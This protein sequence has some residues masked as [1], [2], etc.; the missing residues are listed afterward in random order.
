MGKRFIMNA[1]RT[2]KQGQ[3][4]NVGKDHAEYQAI[5]STLTMHPEDMKEVGIAQGGSVQVRI[6]ARRGHVQVHRGEGARGDDL[7]PVRPADL[8]AHGRRHRRNRD[9][10]LQGLG[11]RGRAGRS[12][13]PGAGVVAVSGEGESM[14]AERIPG[15]SRTRGEDPT[16]PAAPATERAPA[17]EQIETGRYMPAPDPGQLP[18]PGARL[19]IRRAARSGREDGPGAR[20]RM[21]VT[22]VKNATCTFCGCVC[23]D[24]ELHA[25]GERIVKT[26][27]ACSPRRVVVQEPHRRAALPRRPDRRQAGHGRRGGRGR[28]RVPL[29]RRHAAGLRAE[30]HH[31]RGPAR[32]GRAWPS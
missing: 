25:D 1:G 16:P 28:G 14:A 26:K 2:T 17:W 22:I 13:R 27:D 29:R 15:D 20:R 23:D 8:P 18:G 30:Q 12:R 7:R 11:G 4:I 10:H 3:Q 21:T 31:L 5:V 6:R 19:N 9:A 32:G 24:I